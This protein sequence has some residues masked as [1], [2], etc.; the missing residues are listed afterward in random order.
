MLWFYPAPEVPLY[1]FKSAHSHSSSRL[2]LVRFLSN[3]FLI[4][5]HIN[6]K[7][8]MFKTSG[9]EEKKKNKNK[10]IMPKA[11]VTGEIVCCISLSTAFRIHPWGC[12]VLPA[13][14]PQLLSEELG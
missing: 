11:A 13:H 2:S 8:E 12:A 3:P 9:G 1:P 5:E 14:I 6:L 10:K 4:N 7:G